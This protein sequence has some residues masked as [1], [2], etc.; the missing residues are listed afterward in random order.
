MVLLLTALVLALAALV[1]LV[2]SSA[3][4]ANALA[5]NI[6]YDSI[7]SP[8]PANI[9]SVGYEATSTSEFGGQIGL[10]GTARINP[11]VTVLMSSWACENGAWTSGCVT[12]EGATFTHPVTLNIYA[13]NPDDTVGALLASSTDTFTMPYRPSSGDCASATQW[14]DEE[15][16]ACVTGYAFPISFTFTG[17]TL[18][19][20]VIVGVAYN[21]SH[22]GVAPL[23]TAT[24]C[25]G[26]PAGC[27]Y[28]SLNVGTSPAA[29]VGT[30]LP[31]ADDVYLDSTWTDAYCDSAL[32]TGSFRL[33]AGCWGGYLPAL[34][35]SAEYLSPVDKNECKKNG[36]QG[37]ADLGFKNQGQCVSWVE[38]N[39]L[40]HGKQN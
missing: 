8:Q 24:A 28:D 18:P 6:V 32:G 17:V 33:D 40:L 39:V 35:V 5:G 13:V 26:T 31:T 27:P 34:Q 4:N 29:T 30:P 21:T 20:E 7:P 12:T 36:W 1:L 37:Y 25:Y 9:P 19:D 23:G 2:P 14:Y 10:A 15:S 16:D 22:H 11:T 3:R 38:H